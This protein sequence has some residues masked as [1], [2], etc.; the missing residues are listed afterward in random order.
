MAWRVKIAAG[1]RAFTHTVLI[2]G[3]VLAYLLGSLLG[4][5]AQA[6]DPMAPP[7]FKGGEIESST[8]TKKSPKKTKKSGYVLRQIVIHASNKSAV[9]NGYI[10]NEGGYIKDAL[11]KKINK[12]TVELMVSGKKKV[13]TLEARLPR[14]RR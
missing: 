14:I 9:I 10:V 8:A 7:G 3:W 13:L 6:F 11:V 4:V 12:N 1:K 2:R 5:P